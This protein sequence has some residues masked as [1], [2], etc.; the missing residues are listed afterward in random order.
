MYTTTNKLLKDIETTN[1]NLEKHF[2]AVNSI[3][4]LIE[5]IKNKVSSSNYNL[6]FRL[7][8]E[9]TRDSK[10]LKRRMDLLLNKID[11]KKL[12][13]E[14]KELND[15]FGSILD[16]AKEYNSKWADSYVNIHKLLD[17]IVV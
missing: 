2:M 11:K 3:L 17:E 8:S 5:Q 15:E 13:N 14:N 12:E 4:T 1:S 16:L 6:M 9:I 7:S 10:I